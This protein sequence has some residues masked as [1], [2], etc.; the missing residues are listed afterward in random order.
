ME[1]FPLLVIGMSSKCWTFSSSELIEVTYIVLS[2]RRLPEGVMALFRVIAS[3]TWAAERLYILSFVGSTLI[4]TDRALEPKGGGAES[5]GTVANNGLTRVIARSK[6]SFS[7][8]VLL[9]NTSSPTGSELASKRTT[10]G[11]SAPG[12]K[13]AIVR[14]TCKATWADASAMSVLS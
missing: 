10:C 12:G 14:F 13:K 11:G 4:C 2:T 6:I 1:V 3:T 9:L 8:R 5:P 7:D